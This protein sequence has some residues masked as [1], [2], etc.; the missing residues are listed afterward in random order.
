MNK[1]FKNI[2]LGFIFFGTLTSFTVNKKNNLINEN[3][4]PEEQINLLKESFVISNSKNVSLPV[5][6]IDKVHKFKRNEKGGSFRCVTTASGG[7]T[8]VGAYNELYFIFDNGF[9]MPYRT[10]IFKIGNLGEINSFK[11]ITNSKYE[12]KGWMFD[13]KGI[14]SENEVVITIDASD[15]I[16]Q[17]NK[18]NANNTDFEGDLSSK[19]VVSVESK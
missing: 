2:S 17:E 16:K 9:E 18:H 5:E 6:T 3:N 14:Y 4:N 13:F 15:V 8:D 19:L 12:I 1:K 7:A 11:K 10:A